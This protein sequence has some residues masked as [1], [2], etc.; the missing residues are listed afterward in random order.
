MMQVM[1]D[2]GGVE[3]PDTLVTLGGGERPAK[4]DGHTE[5][6][7]PAKHAAPVAGTAAAK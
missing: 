3:I 2:I 4:A 7:G 1:R 6:G 5:N